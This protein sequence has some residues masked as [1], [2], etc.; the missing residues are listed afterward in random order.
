MNGGEI[1]FMAGGKRH[2]LKIESKIFS[3]YVEKII[4]ELKG[5]NDECIKV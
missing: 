3:R 1:D 5:Q 4:Y 2:L